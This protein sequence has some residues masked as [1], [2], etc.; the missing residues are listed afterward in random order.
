MEIE[1]DGL[2]TYKKTACIP[3]QYFLAVKKIQRFDI[4][5]RRDFFRFFSGN[6]MEKKNCGMILRMAEL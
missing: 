2:W 6:R 4:I 5:N 1:Q 3:E